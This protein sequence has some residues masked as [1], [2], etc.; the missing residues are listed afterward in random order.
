MDVASKRML[1]LILNAAKYLISEIVPSCCNLHLP[2]ETRWNRRYAM[3]G[4]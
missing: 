2:V 1:P 4:K 3:L